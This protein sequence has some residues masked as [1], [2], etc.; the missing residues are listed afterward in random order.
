MDVQEVMRSLCSSMN[1]IESEIIALTLEILLGRRG[2][3][4]S[5]TA[6]TAAV[7]TWK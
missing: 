6:S 5:A 1:R 4:R 2:S 7:S 3:S